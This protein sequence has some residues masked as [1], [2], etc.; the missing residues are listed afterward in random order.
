MRVGS[1]ETGQIVQLSLDPGQDLTEKARIHDRD[2]NQMQLIA[3]YWIV[4]SEMSNGITFRLDA[5]KRILVQNYAPST[6]SVPL[7]A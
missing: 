4:R 3:L 1:Q 5:L 7:T 6:R 2:G